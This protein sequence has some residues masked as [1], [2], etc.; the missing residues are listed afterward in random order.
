MKIT[1]EGSDAFHVEYQ[2]TYD[3]YDKIVTKSV[4]L[5]I[6]QYWM[7]KYEDKTFVSWEKIGIGLDN[8]SDNLLDIQGN[9]SHT[10][11]IENRHPGL[12]PRH[13]KL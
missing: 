10:F 2:D 6:I 4:A 13:R 5:R 8:Y 3:E 9:K 12:S 7:K 11:D 1:K